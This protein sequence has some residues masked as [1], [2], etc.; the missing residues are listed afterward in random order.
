VEVELWL[1]SVERARSTCTKIRNVM[2]VLFTH[3]RRYDLFDRNPIQFV[4]QSAKRRKSPDVLTPQEVRRLLGELQPRERLM[5]VLA[6]GTG[7]RQS[8]LFTLKWKDI[9]FDSC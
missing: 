4:R 1:R 3:A 7:L 5:V 9:D 2:S 8:E 6:M